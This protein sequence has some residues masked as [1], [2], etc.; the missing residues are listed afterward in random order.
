MGWE[1][2]C[3]RAILDLRVTLGHKAFSLAPG[4]LYLFLSR[5]ALFFLASGLSSTSGSLFSFSLRAILDLR[6]AFFF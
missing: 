2:A 5:Q 1:M 6:V 4:L 3:P